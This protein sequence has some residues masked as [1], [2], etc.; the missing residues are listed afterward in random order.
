VAVALGLGALAALGAALLLVGRFPERDEHD[1]AAA[2]VVGAVAGGAVTLLATRA[3]LALVA[4]S[5][6][7]PLSPAAVV[8]RFGERAAGTL[9]ADELDRQLVE[10]LRSAL[11]LRRAELWELIG[12]ELVCTTAVPL[13]VPAPVAVDRRQAELLAGVAV[14]GEAWLDLWLP[15]LLGSRDGARL[16]VAPAR[17]GGAVLGL[18]VGERAPADPPFAGADD[19]A[20]A[21]L[22]RRLGVVL[23]NRR[24]DTALQ[25]TLDDLQVANADLRASRARLVAAADDERRRIERDI[26][27]GAQQHLVA[28]AVELGLL[29][30]LVADRPE[31]AAAVAE[32]QQAARET[33]RQLRDLAHGIY[34][35]LLTEAGLGE[36]LRE[37]GLRAAPAVQVTVDAAVGRHPADVETAIYFCCLE[38]IQNASKH[39]PGS[40]V[41]VRARD[42]PTGVQFE[43]ADDGPG[44]DPATA[45]TGHG[46]RTMVDRL[47]A[48]G[49]TV[50]WRSAP[51]QGTT[52]AGWVPA[53][54]D[55]EP[56][57]DRVGDGVGDGLAAGGP[58]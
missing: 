22:G 46:R 18:L 30:E 52:V 38:A 45:T 55:P 51:G 56:V 35:P 11:V 16:R 4:T 6:R 2:G 7:P 17:H 25:G 34:P 5:G 33:F 37:A 49:G 27:D 36:A 15:G 14:V 39:A 28:L 9:P 29:R 48:V 20:L 10:S 41:A 24:L 21:D 8:E 3:G 31:A 57:D 43:V 12:G 19:Q 50:A 32:L 54:G 26:H 58:P 1:F 47:G 53:A 40:H 13:P 44:F 42:D 23:H